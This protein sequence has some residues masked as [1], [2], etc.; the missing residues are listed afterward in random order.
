MH[1][2]EYIAFIDAAQGNG[3]AAP[4][5]KSVETDPSAIIGS[6]VPRIDGPLKTTGTAMYA[7]DYNFPRMVY[8]VPVC[9]TIANGKIRSIDASAAEKLPGVVL[10]LHHGNVSGIYRNGP[11]SGR[12]SENRPPLSDNI[13]SYWGQYVAVVVAETFAQANAAAA[14]VRVQYVAEKSNVSTNLSD[15]MPAIGAPGGPHIQSHRGDPDAAF[16]S[17]PVKIDYTYSTPVETHNPMEMH[18]T[19]AVWRGPRVTLYESSQGVVNHHSV[20]SEVLGLPPENI[21]IISRYIGSGF[22]GKL[23]PWPHSALCAVAARQLNRPV[24]LVVSRKMMFSDVGHRPRTQQH[25][26]LGATPDGKLLSLSQDYL[27]HTS[28]FD[29]IRENCGE[30]TPFLYSTANLRVSSGLVRRNVGTP[31]PMRGP[32]AVPGLFAIES[33][34]DELAIKLNMDPVQLRLGLDTLTDEESGK[35]FSS[36]HLKECLQLGS[37]K[38]GWSRRTPQVGSMRDGDLILGW[39]VACASWGAGRGP[40]QCSVALL[41]DGT[42]RVSSATQ[43]IGTGTYTVIAQVVSDKTGIPINK[44]D[45]ILGDSSLPPGPMSGGSTATASVLPSIVDGVEAAVKNLLAIAVHVPNSPFNGLDDNTLTLTDGRVH[46]KTQ[47]S[48]SGTPFGD[49]LRAANLASARGEGK[50]TGNPNAAKYSMHSFGAQ[51]AE[52]QWDPGIAHLRVS[53]IV[54]VIDGGRI[55]NR[56]AATNQCAGAAVMGVGMT[57]FEQ[58]VY[59]PRNGAPINS[60][61]ADYIVPTS[62]DAPLIGVHFLDIPDPLMGSYGARGIGEIG[63]AGVAPAIT[64]AVYHATGVRVREL[65]VRI[66]DLLAASTNRRDT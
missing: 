35:P 12:A 15:P 9:S 18:A 55:I 44:V 13:V 1:F 56:S 24:K 50:S 30:A 23:F 22:G 11:G 40:S 66:E 31:T 61:F 29:D 33:A 36:R 47:P 49:I 10:V 48:S 39:G 58:T 27:N 41:P 42:A 28:Q 6:N 63:L 3:K 60:N 8:A 65:P 64:A 45:V 52:V 53:R 46:V 7:G 32:G 21:E 51:F 34:M 4:P 2:S 19:T 38:F 14:A 25:V 59:D 54:T 57:L 17:A 62:A 5:Q 37:E 26:R 20:M 43:D 16:A